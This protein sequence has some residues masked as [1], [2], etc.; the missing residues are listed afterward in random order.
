MGNEYTGDMK[1]IMQVPYPAAQI[2]AHLGIERAEGLIE[3]Q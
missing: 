1:L 2:L 3:E